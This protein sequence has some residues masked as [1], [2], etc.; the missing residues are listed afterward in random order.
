MMFSFLFFRYIHLLRRHLIIIFFFFTCILLTNSCIQQQQQNQVS[1]SSVDVFIE[2]NKV[3]PLVFELEGGTQ[4]CRRGLPDE[5]IYGLER[6]ETAEVEEEDEGGGAQE[7]STITTEVGAGWF[8]M[9]LLIVNKSRDYFLIVEHL[10]FAM[11][12]PWGTETLTGRAEINSGYCQSDP[13]YIIPPTPKD[14]T[15]GYVGNRYAPT[16]KNDVNNLTLFV[17]G[18]PIPTEAPQQEENTDDTLN[19][20]RATAQDAVNAPTTTPDVFVL[21]RLPPYRVQLVLTGYWVDQNRNIVANFNKSVR[22]SLS[23]QF[24]Q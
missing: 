7:A 14:R 16:K 9:G 3:D 10:I 23:S 21:D 4:V 1:S 22:F 20:I 15:G 19:S 5:S 18:V 2:P 12:A 8:K 24:I 17:S 6:D 13:L 11:I